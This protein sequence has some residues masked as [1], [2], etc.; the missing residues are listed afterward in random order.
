MAPKANLTK[1]IEQARTALAE[2]D[3]KLAQIGAKR[4]GALLASDDDSAILAL[5]QQID[6][7]GRLGRVIGPA[8]RRWKVKPRRKR[9]QRLQSARPP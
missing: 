7:F 5:D 2:T 6:E 8:S 3:Q 9:L 4:T 1:A